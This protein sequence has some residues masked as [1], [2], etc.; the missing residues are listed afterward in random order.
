MKL[1]DVLHNVSYVIH[2]QFKPVQ[3][4]SI[5]RAQ[6]PNRTETLQER[7][8]VSELLDCNRTVLALLD[9]R[10]LVRPRNRHRSSL[11]EKIGTQ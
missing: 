5:T 1:D 4:A 7:T 2:V 9:V 6:E 11:A 10:W 3:P 8:E